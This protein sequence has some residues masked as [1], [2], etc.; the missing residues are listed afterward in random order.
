[1]SRHSIAVTIGVKMKEHAEMPQL[2]AI[3]GKVSKPWSF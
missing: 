3:D 1:M 2:F